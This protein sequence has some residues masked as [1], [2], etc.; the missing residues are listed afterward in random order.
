MQTRDTCW[1][2]AI[3]VLRG[4]VVTLVLILVLGGA[5]QIPAILAPLYGDLQNSQQAVDQATSD[6]KNAKKVEEKAIT[7]RN[8]RVGGEGARQQDLDW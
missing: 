3:A 1:R 6:W 8:F 5:F 7:D 2:L 4:A